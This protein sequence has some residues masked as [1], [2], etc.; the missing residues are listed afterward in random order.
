MIKINLL[1][2][3]I[4]ERQRIRGVAVLVV[5]VILVEAAVLGMVMMRYKQ[6]LADRQT[7]LQYWKGRAAAVGQLDA[8]IRTT[9]GQIMFYGRWVN[10]NSQIDQYHE[11]W[12]EI[13]GEIAKWIYAKMQV[14]SLSP[15]PGQVQIQGRTTSL[16]AF[17]KAYLNII[18]SPLY[19]PAGVTFSIGGVGGGYNQGLAGARLGAGPRALAGRPAAG[20]G[21]RL[22]FGRGR[23]GGSTPASG[24]PLA[25][26]ARARP[27]RATAGRALAQAGA[28]PIGVTFNCVLL[29]QY[30]TRLN[31]P[32]PPMGG[33][34]AGRGRGGARALPRAGAARFRMSA[35]P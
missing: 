1:P 13:L 28:L 17:R 7:E 23:T 34:P 6:Q 10:W 33:A 5:V 4:L 30:G 19:R 18:R 24:G 35:G 2:A 22:T 31:P 20:R 3:H 25:R 11:S 12:A 32:V 27:M 21:P 9:Q 15:S 29:P 14:D 16:E 8:Q 26:T